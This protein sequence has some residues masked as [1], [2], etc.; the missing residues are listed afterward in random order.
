MKLSIIFNT[1]APALLNYYQ[2]WSVHAEIC[3]VLEVYKKTKNKSLAAF[4]R[5]DFF[6]KEHA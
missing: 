2:L 1:K 3:I 4:I 6:S 5:R